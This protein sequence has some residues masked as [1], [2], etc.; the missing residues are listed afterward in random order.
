M[1]REG[2]IGRRAVPIDPTELVTTDNFKVVTSLPEPLGVAA[3]SGW[4]PGL[5]PD[6][7]Y[8]DR[9]EHDE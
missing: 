6:G 5:C 9:N 7:G 2:A 4:S 1:R 8:P 3:D